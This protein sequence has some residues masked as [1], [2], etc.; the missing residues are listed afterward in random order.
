MVGLALTVKDCP[1]N[2]EAAALRH[3]GRL[4]LG[5]QKSFHTCL[6]PSLRPPCV[7]A[8]RLCE[9]ESPTEDGNIF[10]PYYHKCWYLLDVYHI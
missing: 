2:K 3:R 6:P 4:R 1:S 10:F 9:H 8:S 5:D 7:L